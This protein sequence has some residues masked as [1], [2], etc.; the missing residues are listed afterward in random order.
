[1]TLT[2][3]PP[4]SPSGDMAQSSVW[5]LDE[6]GCICSYRQHNLTGFLSVAFISN[7][8]KNRSQRFNPSAPY[9][10]FVSALYLT[11]HS[12][13]KEASGAWLHLHKY[14]TELFS[15]TEPK[16]QNLV[17]WANSVNDEVPPL[18]LLAHGTRDTHSFKGQHVFCQERATRVQ[19]LCNKSIQ[20]NRACFCCMAMFTNQ[21]CSFWKLW[22]NGS[23][24][25][26]HPRMTE[27]TLEDDSGSAG[28]K[29][30][31]RNGK[32]TPESDRHG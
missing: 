14:S 21:L 4:P 27:S 11:P 1:M 22:R 16:L 9:G 23:F 17:P 18:T 8:W 20:S 32:L 6:W 25:E 7:A 31:L 26:I 10:R 19:A 2:P 12:A 13:G 5:P 24:P 3:A 29:W 28:R 15:P 30:T